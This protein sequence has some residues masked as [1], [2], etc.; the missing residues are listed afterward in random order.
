MAHPSAPAPAIVATPPRWLPLLTGA[1]IGL[2]VLG[3]GLRSGEL[4]NLDPNCAE[5][6]VW[7]GTNADGTLGISNC[8][9]WTATMDNAGLT[10]QLG[11][12]DEAWTQGPCQVACE[13]VLHIYCFEIDP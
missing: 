2:I 8:E 6:A 10:G 3:P 4:L 12:T 7:T 11:A 1:V 13:A 5:E 9:D